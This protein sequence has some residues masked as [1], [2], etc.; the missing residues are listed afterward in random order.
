M[1]SYRCGLDIWWRGGGSTR[2]SLCVPML[3]SWSM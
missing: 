1:T 3:F 2:G